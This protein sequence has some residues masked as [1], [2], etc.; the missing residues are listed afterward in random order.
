MKN[1][2]ILVIRSN[3]NDVRYHC[4]N[5]PF[6]LLFMND[7]RFIY[8]INSFFFVNLIWNLI[9]VAYNKDTFC[10]HLIFLHS[11]IIYFK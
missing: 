8:L 4:I 3:D 5:V 2:Y 1:S 10:H 11:H 6:F 9:I 7:L